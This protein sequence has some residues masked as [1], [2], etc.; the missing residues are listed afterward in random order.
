M[1]AL[2]RAGCTSVSSQLNTRSKTCQPQMM[3]VSNCAPEISVKA[4]HELT[5]AVN[6]RT[7]RFRKG[8]LQLYRLV[9]APIAPSW[10]CSLTVV[11]RRTKMDLALIMQRRTNN[12]LRKFKVLFPSSV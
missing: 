11:R 5:L 1:A 3:R 8:L 10:Y 4:L 7:I 9:T 6:S 2:S 12:A